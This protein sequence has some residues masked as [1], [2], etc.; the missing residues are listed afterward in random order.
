VWF[1]HGIYFNDAEVARLAATGT[2]VAHCPSSNM[3]L[4]SGIPRLPQ[5]LR[6]GVPVG[7]GVDGSSSNDSSDMLGEVRQA[8]L[9]ARAGFGPDALTAADALGLAT[10]GGAALLGRGL[11]LGTIEPGKAADL[12]LF[13]VSG[14]DRAG[15]LAD[16]LAAL[17]FT[18][19]S[20]R[21]QT[22]LV[23][24][25]VVVRD[26]RL[27]GI[28]EDEVARR[29]HEAS[30]RLYRRAGV[31]LPWGTPPWLDGRLHDPGDA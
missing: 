15:A 22:V 10:R 14:L 6:A 12:A 21:A 19:I 30:F 5:L 25:R 11:E 29:A 13:D 28:D 18:G 17:V 8:L 7:L 9:L 26:G 3:R 20:H 1:A 2:G 27:A 16:P 31:R 23:N 24:G 4:G